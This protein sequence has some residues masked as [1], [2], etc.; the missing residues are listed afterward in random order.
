VVGTTWA[1][2]TGGALCSLFRDVPAKSIEGGA[3]HS[4]PVLAGG[5]TGAIFTGRVLPPYTMST[6]SARMTTD[7]MTM[8]APGPG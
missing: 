5:G 1:Q 3:V 4:T 2:P 7:Y 8:S 6:I